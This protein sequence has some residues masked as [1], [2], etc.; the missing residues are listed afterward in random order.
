METTASVGIPENEDAGSLPKTERKR[1]LPIGFIQIMAVIT[2]LI[3]AVL[4]RSFGGEFYEQVR[5]VYV[6]LLSDPI[7]DRELFET[8]GVFHEET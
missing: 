7:D 5:L 4:F 1:G 8:G 2:L 3:A 6:N